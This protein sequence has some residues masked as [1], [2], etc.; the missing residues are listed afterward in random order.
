[1]IAQQSVSSSIDPN[2]IDHWLFDLDNTLYHPRYALFDQIDARMGQFIAELENCDLVAARVIQKHYFHTHGTTLAGLMA[3]HDIS[4]D[5]FLDFVHDIDLDVLPANQQL[6]AALDA[7]P[8]KR[9]IFTNADTPYAVRVLEKLNIAHLFADIFDIRAAGFIPKPQA[10]P[11]AQIC[12]DFAINP[13]RAFFAEDMAR[14]LTPAKALGMRTLWLDNGAE[15]GKR[16]LDVTAIDFIA[17]DLTTWL[18]NI[19]AQ[20]QQ[21]VL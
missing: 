19:S 21:E 13:K 5:Y 8:A 2:T 14:N 12:A 4:A 17:D 15:S 9:Y 10:A 7:L 20:P 11:Y 3:H 18:C 16:D 6:G 1:M